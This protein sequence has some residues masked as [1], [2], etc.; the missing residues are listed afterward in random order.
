MKGKIVRMK[1]VK[2]KRRRQHTN[3]HKRAKGAIHLRTY[4]I[5]VVRYMQYGFHIHER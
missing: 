4:T 2:E 1:G 3:I 5:H